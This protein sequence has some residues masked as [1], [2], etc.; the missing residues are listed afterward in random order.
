MPIWFAKS[1]VLIGSADLLSSTFQNL[2]RMT[3]L[4]AYAQHA[5]MHLQEEFWIGTLGVRKDKID[6]SFP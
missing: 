2:A 1:E 3:Y 5:C 4:F 6:F